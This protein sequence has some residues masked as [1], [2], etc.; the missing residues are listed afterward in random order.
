MDYEYKSEE[1]EIQFCN[2]N[3][4]IKIYVGALILSKHSPLFDQ[5]DTNLSDTVLDILLD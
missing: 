5:S 3:W 1:T 2:V 4:S